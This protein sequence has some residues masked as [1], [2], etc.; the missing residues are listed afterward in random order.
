ML[1]I[2][3]FLTNRKQFVKY[4]YCVSQLYDI[5]SGVIEGPKLNPILFIVFL[6]KLLNVIQYPM[7]FTYADNTL[8]N[9]IFSKDDLNAINEWNEKNNLKLNALKSVHFMRFTLKKSVDIPLYT[10]NGQKIP[11]E[12]NHKHLGVFLDDKL[13]FN[14]YIEYVVTYCIRKWTTLNKLCLFASPHIL[15]QLYKVY[16]LPIVNYCNYT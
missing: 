12:H 2:Y 11:T 9:F 15:L 1:N 4:D 13:S 6:R 14:Y 7:P 5:T 10:I 3:S 16:I 8:I